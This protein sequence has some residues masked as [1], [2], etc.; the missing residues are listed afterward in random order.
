MNDLVERLDHQRATYF[1]QWA[2]GRYAVCER[3]ELEKKSVAD[4]IREYDKT[5]RHI[6]PEF[7]GSRGGD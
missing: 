2:I 7:R 4:L 5:T 6:T 1:I 3:K